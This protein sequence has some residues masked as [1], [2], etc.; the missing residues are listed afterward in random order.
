MHSVFMSGA[1]YE[2]FFTKKI[3]PIYDI[4]IML[5]I[6]LTSLFY[7]IHP[8]GAYQ[9]RSFNGTDVYANNSVQIANLVETG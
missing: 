6:M 5:I 9:I 8:V 3:S 7:H 4:I 1:T 2:N